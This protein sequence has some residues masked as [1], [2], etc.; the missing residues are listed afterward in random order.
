MIALWICAVLGCRTTSE[1]VIQRPVYNGQ[2][3]V[4]E[5]GSEILTWDARTGKLL[6]RVKSQLSPTY[7]NRLDRT[8]LAFI[9]SAGQIQA[10]APHY[11]ED[12]QAL[13][14]RASL[15]WPYQ[16]NEP[17]ISRSALRF[18]PNGKYFLSGYPMGK[19]IWLRQVSWGNLDLLIEG[20]DASFDRS[21][22]QL[23]QVETDHLT[24]WSLPELIQVTT[25]SISA[26]AVRTLTAHFNTSGTSV[27][28]TYTD[29][30]IRVWNA[31]S[32][33]LT[34]TLAV[35]SK[36]VEAGFADDQ[37]IVFATEDGTI[38]R[39]DL[40]LKKLLPAISVNGRISRMLLSRLG[41]YCAVALSKS[42]ERQSIVGGSL[43]DL[44]KGKRISDLGPEEAKGALGFGTV[45][46]DF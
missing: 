1:Q 42:S 40:K 13:W 18:S 14:G 23:L 33:A 24:I 34:S 11:D 32:G 9:A 41:R 46:L 16:V 35:R 37:T 38:Q 12:D 3:I 28:G 21:G 39:W 5:V 30:R 45:D 44:N 25:I 17:V 7:G 10:R 4:G 2:Q 20:A 22:A 15:A 19:Q 29:Q 6:G 31:K 36:L 27:V 26:P 43:W 8:S